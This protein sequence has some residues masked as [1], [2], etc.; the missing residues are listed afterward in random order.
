MKRRQFIQS[1]LTGLAASGLAVRAYAE[2][3]EK[4]RR[5]GVI[6]PGWYGKTDLYALCQV[7]PVEVVAMSDPDAHMM[8]AAADRAAT[9]H[10]SGKTPAQYRDYRKMLDEHE[11]DIVLIDTPDHWHALPM[12]AAVQ[13][14]ADVYQ[15]KPISVDIVEGQAMV[16]AARKH[17]RVVQVGTQ[18]RSTPHL[19]QAIDE[20]IKEGR[21][22]RIGHVEIC[23][24]YGMGRNLHAKDS[25]PPT[26]LD[27]DLWTGPA[28]MRPYNPAV[29]PRRWRVFW[30]YGNGI[31]GDMCI[32]MLDMVRWMLD[33]D[34][35][36]RVYST[37]GIYV[38]RDSIANV[39]DAQTATFEYPDF[40]VVWTHRTWGT[41]PDP[42][43]P[44]AAFI[45]GEK[46]TLKASVASWDFVPHG[47]G[48]A[49]H[50]DLLVEDDQYPQ[51]LQNKDLEPRT[52]PANR[53]H[54]LDFLSA[55]DQRTRPAADIMQ[56]HIST[57][58]CIL[59]NMS[60]K[61]GRALEWDAEAQVVPGDEEANAMLAR[62]YREPW[63][64]PDPQ[65][66]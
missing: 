55:V 20:V 64:H 25:A 14:G 21:L 22:G 26:H 8:R 36:R 66:V 18:R 29:H 54:Q 11:F 60:L 49:I 33:L 43:Y 27:Y 53:R 30:E 23:C 10:D 42:Q 52:G 35:P 2:G 48:Q 1:S 12:I 51:D 59:A 7:A 13:A 56:G 15:Q 57:A 44:W 62:P 50:R 28:P 40:N 58:S 32:H 19:I 65:Q 39:P 5:V 3:R 16:A 61:L 37:G 24:Y 9:W 34:W 46:G 41:P 63:V 38:E 17:Q 4:K 45:Y 31:V 6:G 47:Q